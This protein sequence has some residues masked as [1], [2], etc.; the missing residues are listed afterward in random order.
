MLLTIMMAAQ[1]GPSTTITAEVEPPEWERVRRALL[2]VSS[3]LLEVFPAR[4]AQLAGRDLI[5]PKGAQPLLNYRFDTDISTSTDPGSG[6]LKLNHATQPNATFLSFDRLTN[7]GIDVT[8]LLDMTDAA[9]QFVIHEKD[10]ALKYQIWKKT[11]AVVDRTDWFKV[12]VV[13]VSG[14]TAFIQNQHASGVD[15]VVRHVYR[16]VR[17]PRLEL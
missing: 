2:A 15:Q 10:L 9:E 8:M 14:T 17:I 4:S 16:P 11:G 3:P 13:Y 5:V 6:K 1:F 7:D 12:P